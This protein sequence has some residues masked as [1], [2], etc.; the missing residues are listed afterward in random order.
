MSWDENMW[1]SAVNLAETAVGGGTKP[2]IHTVDPE[3]LSGGEAVDVLPA[4]SEIL[5]LWENQILFIGYKTETTERLKG[6]K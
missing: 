5:K 3:F 6:E 2:V 4:F 1:L